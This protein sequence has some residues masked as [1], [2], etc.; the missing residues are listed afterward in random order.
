MAEL[1]S[2]A[3]YLRSAAMAVR[4]VRHKYHPI[5][6]PHAPGRLERRQSIAFTAMTIQA[7]FT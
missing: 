5:L 6:Q 3:E 4:E 2:P 7:W 1:R